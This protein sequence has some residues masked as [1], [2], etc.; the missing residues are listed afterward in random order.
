MALDFILLHFLQ[1]VCLSFAV[2]GFP[3]VLKPHVAYYLLSFRLKPQVTY[4]L[5]LFGLLDVVLM[6]YKIIIY[7]QGIRENSG[8]Y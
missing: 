4:H 3:D 5:Q 2:F 6:K 1:V 7:L 8:C